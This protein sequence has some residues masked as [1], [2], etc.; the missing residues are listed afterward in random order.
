[1]EQMRIC[2]QNLGAYNEGELRYKWL[3]LP[4]SEDE[5]AETLLAIGIDGV[6]YEEY[7]L[8]DWEYINASEYAS[9]TVLNELAEEI[10]WVA[11]KHPNVSY[12]TIKNLLND[13]EASELSDVLEEAYVIHVPDNM[14]D[15][16]AVAYY[17]GENYPELQEDTFL[18]RHF[19]Y[20]SW[21]RELMED[22]NDYSGDSGI[23]VLVSNCR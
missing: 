16:E 17:F 23:L 1:M 3:D 18:T 19:D 9:I 5:I 10:E 13:Y 21:G 11:T 6:K 7:M 8:A 4:A 15:E 22:Y 20:D 14:T 12:E 2:I